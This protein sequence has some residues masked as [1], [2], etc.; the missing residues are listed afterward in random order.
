MHIINL[1]LNQPVDC[2]GQELKILFSFEVRLFFSVA[3]L[4]VVTV[5]QRQAE[6]YF[7]LILQH[8]KSLTL[9]NTGA[10]AR[11]RARLFRSASTCLWRSSLLSSSRCRRSFWQVCNDLITP[12]TFFF[13]T[14]FLCNISSFRNA[15][16]EECSVAN[17][18]NSQKHCKKEK[19]INT[20]SPF[21]QF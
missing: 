18:R 3:F 4:A 8:Y 15:L 2:L 5:R 12:I 14:L 9:T 7:D 10:N 17:S 6:K 1:D 21:E 13:R 16:K 11:S 19:D 20:N